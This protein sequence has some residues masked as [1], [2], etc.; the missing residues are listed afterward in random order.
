MLRT[1]TRALAR[2]RLPTTPRTL[3]T[4]TQVPISPTAV[5]DLTTT[6]EATLTLLSSNAIPPD[7]TYA[8]AVRALTTRKLEA[9]RGAGTELGAVEEAL[10][11]IGEIGKG[12]LR[13][14]EGIE[15]ALDTA[16]DELSTARA[17]AEWKA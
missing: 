5:T 17:M 6:Y 8:S 1:A 11:R 10:R 13:A 14:D 2:T 3:A 12:G 7:S 4:L 15:G 9:V 16:R